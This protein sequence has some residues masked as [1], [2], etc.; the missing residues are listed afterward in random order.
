MVDSVIFF[1][2]DDS[3][4][5]HSWQ[6]IG[7]NV[8][9]AERRRFS[10][11]KPA[12]AL[13]R[14]KPFCRLA[15]GAGNSP[16]LRTG[17]YFGGAAKPPAEKRKHGYPRKI[18]ISTSRREGASRCAGARWGVHFCPVSASRSIPPDGDDEFA[19]H[20]APTK[21]VSTC[22]GRCIPLVP[23]VTPTNSFLLPSRRPRR[24]VAGRLGSSPRGCTPPENRTA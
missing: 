19:P 23:D 8:R 14:L 24:P 1:F 11:P 15:P 13:S 22:C 6:S 18:T 10:G 3:K 17:T 7:G 5:S 21:R 4:P 12:G 20:R 2:K 9:R 16:L